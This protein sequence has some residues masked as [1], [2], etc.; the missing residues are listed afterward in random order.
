MYEYIFT[1]VHSDFATFKTK[2]ILIMKIDTHFQLMYQ[3]ILILKCYNVK[4][5]FFF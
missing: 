5:I 3:R 4:P 2:Y 1:F